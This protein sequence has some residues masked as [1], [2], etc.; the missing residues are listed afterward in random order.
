VG[1][2][3][4]A[5]LLARCECEPADVLGMGERRCAEQQRGGEAG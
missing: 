2:E 3:N 4:R 1:A 5:R